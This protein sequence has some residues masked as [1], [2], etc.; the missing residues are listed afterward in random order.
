[1]TTLRSMTDALA[2]TAAERVARDDFWTGWSGEPV[3]GA[4][5]AEHLEDVT[6]LLEK[7]G[8]VRN[9][10]DDP[11]LPEADE[12]MSVKALLLAGLRALRSLVKDTGPLTL[13]SA[14]FEIGHATSDTDTKV[15]ADRVLD[16]L[17]RDFT[18]HPGAMHNPW[19]EKRGRTWDE[20]RDLLTAAAEFA[21]VHGPRA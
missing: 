15:V 10:Q 16:E 1:M 7:R 19:A 8:W 21:R 18:R 9:T 3:T 11:Q 6:A 4:A 2:T 12:S 5:V 20:V 13:M 17:V 14:T